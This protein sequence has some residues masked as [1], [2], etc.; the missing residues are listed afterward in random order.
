MIH[1]VR[2][3]AIDYD[4]T[5]TS[6]ETPTDDVLAALRETRARGLLLLLVTG[7]IVSELL[8][9]FPNVGDYFD[10]VVA[11]NGAVL[12]SE[13]GGLRCLVPP[14][15]F[16]LGAALKARGVPMTRGEV[17]L[18]M[19]AI[20]D[21]VALEEISRLGLDSQLVRNRAALMILPAGVSKGSGLSEA[22]GELGISHHN[23][24]GLGDAEND[25]ALLE[26]CEVG[27]AVENAI[28]ALKAHADMVLTEPDGGGIARFLRELLRGEVPRI[29]PNRWRVPIG[30][31][32]DRL[33][34]TLPGSGINVIIAGPSGSGKSYLAGLLAERLVRLGYAICVF[35]PEGDHTNLGHLRGIVTL[36]GRE[37]MPH[38]S[39]LAR[40]LER[41]FGGEVLDMSLLRSDEQESYTTLALE[42]LR[43]S[44]S[45]LGLPHWIFIDEAHAA[46]GARAIHLDSFDPS[47]KGFCL[48]TY[49]PSELCRKALLASDI[50]FLL[51]GS[52]AL[53]RELLSVRPE[54]SN[55][56]V[57][58]VVSQVT[59]LS[60][61]EALMLNLGANERTVVVQLGARRSTHVRHWHKYVHGHLAP[62]QHFFFCDASG[63][64]GRW[65][66][67]MED[68]HRELQ[69][70]SA[71]VLQH[72][73]S[74][75]DFSRWVAEVIQDGALASDVRRLETPKSD[76]P[77]DVEGIRRA[78]LALIERRY[79]SEEKAT[80]STLPP[81]G[82]PS[83]SNGVAPVATRARVAS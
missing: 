80:P 29:V 62:R 72:H 52:Q 79:G 32:K 39:E 66:A 4:G 40:L 70:C 28:A 31:S 63:R 12:W 37:G 41:R 13:S 27:I 76:E 82:Q 71:S 47:Q 67:N 19:D 77:V 43:Q 17:L 50:L 75:G 74:C 44:R 25:H 18:A 8:R 36:G 46:V 48:V 35:D 78:L 69:L 55:I 58:Q 2:A 38:H 15:S 3:I 68:F 6:G 53:A 33:P 42:H 61:G 64:T 60:R 21:R 5:L 49:H 57:A 54:G 59:A 22:L 11:E 26:A 34:I 14:M 10:V 30:T 56:D 81:S 1:S 73:L 83:R 9:S 16:E 7:R 20:H 24:I 51:P 23:A 65:A 45:T